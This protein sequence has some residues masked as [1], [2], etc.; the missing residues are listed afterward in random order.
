MGERRGPGRPEQ[1]E[2]LA[3]EWERRRPAVLGVAHRLLGSVADAE[4]VAQ[5]VWLRAAGADP[6]D[7]VICGPGW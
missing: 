3:V 6:R 1:E 5:D 4:D 7:I 2:P